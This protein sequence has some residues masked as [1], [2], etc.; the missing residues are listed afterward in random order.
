MIQR[1]GVILLKCPH[2]SLP[3]SLSFLRPSPERVPLFS[4]QSISLPKKI[5]SEMSG[6]RSDDEVLAWIASLPKKIMRDSVVWDCFIIKFREKPCLFTPQLE[7]Y[8]W[9]ISNTRLLKKS[10]PKTYG[11]NL[12]GKT[13]LAFFFFKKRIADERKSHFSIWA[14][15]IFLVIYYEK[16]P[17]D[18]G[19]H[20]V[21]ACAYKQLLTTYGTVLR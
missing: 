5:K 16:R 6:F 1:F 9:A 7:V 19:L 2:F 15:K 10:R 4:L 11:W 18:Y 8:F 20:G 3:P 17:V 12:L 13:C 21:Q 14:N